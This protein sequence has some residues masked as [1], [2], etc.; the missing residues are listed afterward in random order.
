M[1]NYTINP[2]KISLRKRDI[3]GLNKN[4]KSVLKLG[5]AEIC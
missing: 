5:Y 1:E 2:M 3:K 4:Y